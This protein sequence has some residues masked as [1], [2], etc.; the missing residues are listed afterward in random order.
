MAID[1]DGA[2]LPA[3]EQGAEVVPYA[4]VRLI[5]AVDEGVNCAERSSIPNNVKLRNIRAMCR[6]PRC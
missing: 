5:D 2:R 4:P 1:N 6:V 3:N